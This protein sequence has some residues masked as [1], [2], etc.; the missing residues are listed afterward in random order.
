MPWRWGH[1]RQKSWIVDADIKDGQVTPSEH[2]TVQVGSISLRL[3]SI[4]L[5][6]AFGPWVEQWRRRHG[7]G[8]LIIVRNADDWVAAVQY[9]DDAARVQCAV[10]ERLGQCGPCRRS[11]A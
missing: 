5:R 9:R 4:Y 10:A 6:Q 3:A 11:Q 8:D 7:R 1:S 2:G